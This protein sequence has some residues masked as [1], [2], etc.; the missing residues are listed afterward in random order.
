VLVTR[1]RSQADELIALLDA[2]GARVVVAPTIRIAPPE[3]PGPLNDAAANVTRFDWIVFASANGVDAFL[4]A[5][6]AVSRRTGDSDP[7]TQGEFPA[8]AAVGSRTAE[9]LRARGVDVAVVPEEFQAEALVA[10]LTAR[11][12]LAGARILIPRSAIGRELIANGLRAAGALVSEVVAY[13]TV[14]DTTSSDAAGVR[15]LLA[16]G[17]L[18]AVTFTSGSAVGNFV[19]LHG[20][21]A[22]ALLR[23]TVVAAIGPVTAEIARQLGIDVQ[24]Q[25]ATYTAAAMVTALR[26]YFARR[27]PSPAA[28]R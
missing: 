26:E 8:V 22:V 1:P 27:E 3:D 10:A 24:V 21:E 11:A 23:D 4:D 2:E 5:L 16:H 20:H 19:Q 6:R 12:S 28:R 17:G 14:A 7:T 9:R 15:D 18:D 25:P 13:Q